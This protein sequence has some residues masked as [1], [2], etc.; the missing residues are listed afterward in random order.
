M[1]SAIRFELAGAEAR[2]IL[3]RPEIG[4]ALQLDDIVAASRWIV[5]LRDAPGMKVLRIC[6]EGATFCAGRA[7]GATA[8]RP[9]NPESTRLNLVAPILDLYRALH[10]ADF[11]SIA[12][13]QG[14]ARGLGCALTTACDLVVAARSASFSLPEMDKD[15]P[16]TLALSAVLPSVHLKAAAGLVLGALSVDAQTALAVGLASEVVEDAGLVARVDAIV[17]H[18]ASRHTV[19]LKTVKRYL[20]AAGAPHQ[21]NNAELA[22]SLLSG[23]MTA[24]RAA[25]PKNV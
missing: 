17:A 19:A 1:T 14:D 3:C 4:N 6:A 18:L 11:V 24:I 13:V 22:A 10:D 16:P 23:A 5:G 25:D 7:A 12:Q 21:Q 20:R 2:F 15:L 8:P 9:D